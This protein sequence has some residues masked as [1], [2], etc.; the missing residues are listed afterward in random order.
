MLGKTPEALNTLY[1]QWMTEIQGNPALT[2]AD[3]RDLFEHWGD[4]TAEPGDADYIMEDVNGLK[5]LWVAPKSGVQSKVL[6]CAHG[7]GYVL[8]SMYSHR[9]LFGHFAARVGC[10]ALIV[11]YRRAPEYPHPQPV[12]D[13][14]DA[15]RWLLECGAVAGPQD[16]AFLGDSAGG[17]LAITTML[18]ARARGLPMPAAAV[19]LAPYL[20]MEALGE[21]YDRNAAFDM[22]GS[23]QGNLRFISVFLGAQGDPRD[24]LANPLF[25]DLTGLPPI[26]L[27]VGGHDVL[28]DD[29]V[30]F[31]ARA[32]AAGIYTTLDIAP[33]MPHVFQ[34]LAGNVPQAD[35]AIARAAAWVKPYIGLA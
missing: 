7:G 11:N 24:P 21:S 9:K 22:L 19:A 4:V 23:R 32:K 10:R 18:L 30:R 1:R 5:A 8:G 31:H 28:A 33:E 2:I 13:M 27:Q 17:A 25:A 34:F 3:I 26:F 14:A 29:S 12:N 15:Y 35:E 16:V 6:L 20:D